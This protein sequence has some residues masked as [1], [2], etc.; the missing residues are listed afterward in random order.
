MRVLLNCGYNQ[1]LFGE[2]ANVGELIA[3]IDGAV[4]V[5]EKGGF[6]LFTILNVPCQISVTHNQKGDK[7]YANISSIMGLP[8][9]V[10]VPE[11]ET[12]I[13]S[14]SPYDPEKS[15][16]SILPDWLKKKCSTGHNRSSEPAPEQEYDQQ[17]PPADYSD[18]PF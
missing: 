7:V 6:D 3:A 18:V 10:N 13:L 8:P 14:Y 17:G 11:R 2:G 1:I 5:T 15:D 4:H 9:G 12:D 16:E